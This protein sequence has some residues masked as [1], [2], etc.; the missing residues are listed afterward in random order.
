MA[1]FE[2]KNTRINQFQ[3]LKI[4]HFRG[5]KSKLNLL[6]DWS[7]GFIEQRKTTIFLCENGRRH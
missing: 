7:P 6:S 3:A 1:H 2:I 4:H 5:L